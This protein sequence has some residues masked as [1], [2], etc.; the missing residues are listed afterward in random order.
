MAFVW[1]PV[2]DEEN[3]HKHHI[4]FSTAEL[5]FDDPLRIKRRDDD[6][7]I[8]AERYQSI[9]VADAAFFVVYTE[10]GPEDTRLI[11]ARLATA[12][13]RRIY[14]GGTGTTYPYGWVRSDS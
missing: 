7:S 2:K 5:I 4:H 11:T 6:S 12:K 3:F 8:A 9:G 14:H 1:D 13:E 10:E